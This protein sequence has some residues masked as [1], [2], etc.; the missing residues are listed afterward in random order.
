MI[1]RANLLHDAACDR[2]VEQ[3]RDS[4]MLQWPALKLVLETPFVV[5]KCM[6]L[7][8]MQTEMAFLIHMLSAMTYY[9]KPSNFKPC[10]SCLTS[11]R[12]LGLLSV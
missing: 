4:A 12:G 3:M 9:W 1:A 6:R 7:A 11:Q 5:H 8:F 10:V 2:L